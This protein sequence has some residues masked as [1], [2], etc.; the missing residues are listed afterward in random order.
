[1]SHYAD[2]LKEREGK[3]VLETE[4]GFV[5]FQISGAECYIQDIYVVP[6]KRQ[7]RVATVLADCVKDIA[8]A[9]G[10]TWLSGSVSPST[11]NSHKSLLV[12][13]GYGMKLVKSDKDIVYFAKRIDSNG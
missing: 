5:T 10:C 11:S 9:K 3:E 12:L 4:D 1:M 2:Y 13:L 8:L 6:E 7:S